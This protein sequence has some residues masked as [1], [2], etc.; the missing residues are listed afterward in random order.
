MKRIL[1]ASSEA[2]PF[3]KTGGLADVIGSLPFAF[4]KKEYDVRVIMPK[5]GSIPKEF[6]DQMNFI[7]QINVSLGWRNKYCGIFE[8]EYKGITFYFIDDE[9]YFGAQ[10]LYSYIHHDIEKFA[11]F[12]KA[13]LSILPHINFRPDLIHCNDWQTGLI[14]VY[15]NIQ[16]QHDEFYRGI[17]TIMT[18]HNLKFQGIWGLNETQDATGLPEYVFTPDKLEFKNDANLLKG[19]IVYADHITTVSE[20][21][22]NEIQ[23]PYYGEQLDG[24]LRARD[25]SL[26]GIVNG[27]DYKIYDPSNDNLIF[28]KYNRRDFASRKRENKAALQK[29]LG[30]PII[31]TSFMIGLISRLTDQKGLDLIAYIMDRFIEHDIQ[32]VILGTGDPK[33]ESMFQ[34]YAHKYPDKISANITFS[35]DLAHKI[36]A[37]SDAFLM[38]S[39]FE[40]CGL[41]Q[42]ISMR[43]GTLPIVRE[44]GGLKDT[45]IPYNQYTGE[46][47]GFSFINYNGAELWDAIWLAKTVYES[48]TDW[49]NIVRQAMAKDFSWEKSAKRYADLYNSLLED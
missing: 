37:A 47:T 15:L 29:L 25:N 16:Y 48:K 6:T 24:L 26:S 45:V 43:Y 14:P 10:T 12:S 5:Y 38:P 33:Y 23:T 8:L 34:E 19:G 27:I 3:A 17:K 2:V 9:F 32:L 11:F 1:L 40:P 44:T 41:S 30:L 31:K 21:Y 35:N 46:G 28:A 36:Y 7:T 13:V 39:L 49:N 20:T 18:I 22:R 4:D 42:L